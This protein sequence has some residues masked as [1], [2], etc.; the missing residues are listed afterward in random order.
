MYSPETMAGPTAA[1]I[2]AHGS[3]MTSPV[4]P[5]PITA[6]SM[7][8]PAAISTAS[9]TPA[10]SAAIVRA[11]SAVVDAISEEEDSVVVVSGARILGKR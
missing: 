9:A 11:D 3:R 2:T 1:V 10:M 6:A 8:K 4:G 7:S 5:M